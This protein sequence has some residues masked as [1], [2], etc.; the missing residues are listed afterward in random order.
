[1]TLEAHSAFVQ[2][3]NTVLTKTRCAQGGLA[4]TTPQ[5]SQGL[6]GPAGSAEVLSSH[7]MTKQFTLIDQGPAARS[8][9]PARVSEL[10]R[11][12]AHPNE[13]RL[14]KEL[15]KARGLRAT[16]LAHAA[17]DGQR[18]SMLVFLLCGLRGFPAAISGQFSSSSLSPSFARGRR[19][20]GFFQSHGVPRG[21]CFAATAS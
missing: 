17:P 9:Q 5:R 4:R 6:S 12:R 21:A 2:D 16:G 3:T 11:R 7:F 20:T 13:A 1:M 10:T 18:S 8:V 15:F 14:R 19:T